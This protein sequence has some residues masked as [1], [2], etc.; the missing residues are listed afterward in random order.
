MKNQLILPGEIVKKDNELIRSKLD[1]PAGVDGSRILAALISLI[2]THEPFNPDK[3][4]SIAIKNIIKNPDGHSYQKV[5]EICKELKKSSVAIEMFLTQGEEEYIDFPFFSMIHYKKGIV[6]AKFNFL[7]EKFLF[8]LTECFTEYSL[9]E[10]LQL[11]SM[12][13][14]RLFEIL[15]SYSNLTEQEILLEDLHRYLSTPKS[16]VSNFGL[17]KKEILSKAHREIISKTNFYFDYEPIKGGKGGRTSPVIAIKFVFTKKKIAPIKEKREKEQKEKEKIKQKKKS[18]E[19]N[20]N[21]TIAFQCAK[22]CKG[23]CSNLANKPD[24]TI[25]ELCKKGSM[26]EEVKRKQPKKTTYKSGRV[27]IEQA[28]FFEVLEN[29]K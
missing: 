24:A 1:I 13:S 17:F 9:L 4:Y 10:Y 27:D 15:K 18:Q 21:F 25:C 20:K 12:Y 3:T 26:C 7:M 2:N 6:S 23:D 22:S 5:K 29:K 28:N 11:S 8:T 19:I 14:Q 16:Q